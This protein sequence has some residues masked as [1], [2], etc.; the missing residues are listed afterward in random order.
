MS[1]NLKRPVLGLS[2]AALVATSL[3]CQQDTLNQINA[4]LAPIASTSKSV[5]DARLPTVA[6]ATAL[7]GMELMRALAKP[8]GGSNAL[9]AAGGL[10][11][12]VLDLT[13]GINKK[14]SIK[15]NGVDATVEYDSAVKD[16]GTIESSIKS[17]AGKTSGYDITAQGKFVYTPV[18]KGSGG[19]L[20]T[21]SAEMTGALSRG[22]LKVKLSTLRFATED[23]MPQDVTKLGEIILDIESGKVQQR[24]TAALSVM[25]GQVS[26]EAQV[27]QDG[28]PVGEKITL[29]Q[30]GV[31]G[32]K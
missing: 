20:G 1:M 2:L 8:S 15:S 3:G 6:I 11:Y 24:L 21:V 23:P 13:A 10:N 18:R 14:E 28:K 27:T 17:F 30:T 31:S 26:G 4:G 19:I 16:D 7:G 29:S 5:G 22:D 25:N 12:R 9:V 32:A